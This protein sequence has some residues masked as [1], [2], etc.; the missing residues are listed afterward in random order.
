METKATTMAATTMMAARMLSCWWLQ[1]QALDGAM[2]AGRSRHECGGDG[3]GN[4]VAQGTVS[5]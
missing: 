4:I 5:G 3:G 2:R 1:E